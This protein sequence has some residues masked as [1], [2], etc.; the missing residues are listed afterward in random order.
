VSTLVERKMQSVVALFMEFYELIANNSRLFMPVRILDFLNE[1]SKRE[2]S[3]CHAD[4]YNLVLSLCTFLF[5]PICTYT[6]VNIITKSHVKTS[7]TFGWE[8]K[9]SSCFMF[10]VPFPRCVARFPTSSSG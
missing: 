7:C 1:I 8:G 9:L 5:Q 3:L 2:N 6:H 4:N 10:G